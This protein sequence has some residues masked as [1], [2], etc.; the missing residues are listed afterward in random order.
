MGISFNADEIF[1]MAV[2]IERN[3]AGFYT[4]AAKKAPDEKTKKMFLD[5]ASMEKGH[6][7]TFELMRKELSEQEKESN[8]YD[9][10]DE[11]T[12]YLQTMADAH[13]SEGKVSPHQKLT[14]NEP[15]ADILN[16]AINAEKNSVVFYSGL[17]G[18]VPEKAGKDKV[19]AIIKEEISHIAML[20]NAL[21]EIGN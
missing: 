14:G 6:V 4:E 16:I 5:M 8:I 10:D 15:I 2:E 13:G 17:K 1:E 3:A 12:A 9:P 18:Y 7:D 11:A 19:E 21:A 20:R